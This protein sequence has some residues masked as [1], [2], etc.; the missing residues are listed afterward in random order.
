MIRSTSLLVL[1]LAATSV[2]VE[3]SAAEVERPGM[4]KTVAQKKKKKKAAEQPPRGPAEGLP[5][6][7]A[8]AAGT[9]TTPAPVPAPSAESARAPA[10]TPSQD[11]AAGAASA[12]APVGAPTGESPAAAPPPS[13]AAEAG[14]DGPRTDAPAIPAGPPPAKAAAA[15]VATVEETPIDSE[16]LEALLDSSVVSGASRTAEKADDAPATTTTITADDLRRYGLRSLGE[17]LNFLS[18]GMYSQDPLHS[19]EVGARGVLLSG[20]YGNHVLLVVDGNIMNEPWN[21]T[22]YFEQGA[23]IPLELIDHI[24]VIVGAGSVLYGSYAMLGVIN[25]VTKA[26]KD[27]KG[28]Q[29]TVELSGSPPVNSKGSAVV[30]PDGAGGTL[31]V[32]V[33]AAQEFSLGGKQGQ[34]VVGVEYYGQNGPTF[35]FPA[36]YNSA[37]LDGT[38]ASD[39]ALRGCREGSMNSGPGRVAQP[40]VWGGRAKGAY[41]THVPTALAKAQWGDFSAFV[42]GTYYKRLQP[43][44]GLFGT[45]SGDFGEPRGFERDRTVVGELKW[46]KTLTPELS[47]L[48]RLYGANYDYTFDTYSHNWEVDG[49]PMNQPTAADVAS[50]FTYRQVGISQWGG[51]ELQSTYDFTADGRFPLLVGVDN[52]IRRIGYLNA[53]ADVATGESYGSYGHYD[54]VEWLVAPYLQQRA[55]IDRNWQ[56]NAGVRLDAQKDF[57]PAFS[58]RLALVYSEPS[59]GIIKLVGSSAFRTPTG[60]ERF[61]TVPGDQVANPGLVPERVWTGELS[62]ERR[63]GKVRALGGVFYSHFSHMVSFGPSGQVENGTDLNWFANGGT[64]QN[65]GFNGL[66]EGSW[67]SLRYGA[68]LTLAKTKS[69]PG[70]GTGSRDLTL[71]PSVFGNLHASYEFPK[72]IPVLSTA[73]AI[74]GPRLADGAYEPANAGVTSVAWRDASLAPTQIDWRVIATGDVSLVKGLTYRVMGN[75]ALHDRM[76]YVIGPATDNATAPLLTPVNRFTLMAGLQYALDIL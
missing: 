35:G 61:T 49:G 6:A 8:A 16:D 20:D 65:F 5:K 32:G 73:L 19:V 70:D 33:S 69:D 40:C 37:D 7:P 57:A 9:P 76:P 31:R 30:T 39:P 23:G 28:V 12:V 17:A 63:F 64:I 44:F 14:P 25:V 66:F 36:M 24:E 52:R 3:A 54:R 51:L 59:I 55:K 68:S 2:V 34:Y 22:A 62:Y 29:S 47:A 53:N 60:Y 74:I 38:T 50:G 75:V 4:G 15:G 56:L 18:V 71:S 67:E 46:Q 41:Y 45:S 26:A 72:P 21:G 58:P 10:S 27:A 42:K 48:A 11:S 13:T 43:A 1:A